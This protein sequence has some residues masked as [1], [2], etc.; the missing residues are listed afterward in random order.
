MK[1][2]VIVLPEAK[3]EVTEA[4]NWYE[5][6]RTGQGDA[7]LDALGDALQRIGDHHRPHFAAPRVLA[8]EVNQAPP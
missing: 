8:Q 4:T 6:N 1:L 5:A 7:F 2:Q 3:A